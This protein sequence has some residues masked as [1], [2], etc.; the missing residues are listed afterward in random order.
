MNELKLSELISQS[1]SGSLSEPEQ[2]E[3]REQI[4]RCSP[5]ARSFAS[6]SALIHNSVVHVASDESVIERS[7]EK[8][9]AIA[10]ERLKKSIRAA[11]SSLSRASSVTDERRQAQDLVEQGTAYFSSESDDIHTE[12]RHA[13]S[14][15]TLT[16]K[17]GEGGLGTVWLA[18]DEKLKRN[19]ALKEM[20]P[21]AA[22]SPKLWKRFQR[23]AEI[24]GQL[25]HPN[26]VP[27]YMSGVNPETGMPFYAMRFLGKQTLLD[28]I[29]EFHAQEETRKDPIRLHRLLTVFLDVCQAIAFAHSRGVIHRDLKPENVALDN[30]G[31]VLVLDWGLAK[32]DTEGELGTRLALSGMVNDSEVAQTLD[33]DVVGTP[34]Y[35]SPEQASGEMELLDERTDVYGL[36]AILF[37]ILTGFAPHEQSNKSLGGS[38][39]VS[40]FL[41]AIAASDS[42]QPRAYNALVPRDLELICMKAMAKNRY[43]RHTSAV[44]LA[45][46][47]EAWIAGKHERQTQY[48]SM[49]MAGRD[50]KSRLCVQFRQLAATTQFMVELPPIQGLLAHV[51][52]N[53]DTDYGTWR[54]RLSK[55]LMALAKTKAN[56][57]GLSFAQIEEGRIH[58]LVRIERSLQDVSNIRTLPHSRLRRGAASTFHKVVMQQFPGECCFDL[59]FSTAGQVRVVCGV[60]VFDSTSEEPFG[61]VLAEAE[62]GNLVGPELQMIGTKSRVLLV[63]DHD[64]VIFDSSAAMRS[65]EEVN[66]NDL[67]DRWSEIRDSGSG[68]YIETDREYYS[69]ILS[70]PQRNNSIRIVM[71]VVD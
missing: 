34:L 52:G 18:R 50:L 15:F 35:M 53:S 71:Q 42:P 49:R 19:V 7:G 54:E 17:I 9:S 36:G 69:N 24:T 29:H 30:F 1:L 23:E 13:V 3:L 48:D 33:G 11:S 70:F 55:I 45:E 10:K 21:G 59:D 32:L 39:K 66:A 31:Q 2:S 37:A 6:L 68:E 43:A 20:R 57:S 4:D 8:L 41:K 5:E 22:D 62:V 27:L 28:A 47:V 12:T 25:E 58:E 44:N 14:R 64:K 16:R 40:D 38:V 65:S 61:I 67:I 26:V 56:I 46:D 63:D 51:G 60:P